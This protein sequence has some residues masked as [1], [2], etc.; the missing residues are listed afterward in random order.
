MKKIFFLIA[1]CS[2][3]L[4]AQEINMKNI[5]T[6]KF[7]FLNI[8][9]CTPGREK[10]LAAQAVDYVKHT[11][12]D[13]VLYSLTLHPEGF[14]AMDKPRKL[15]ESYRALKA[16]LAGTNVKLGILLQAIIGHWPRV[17]KNIE[18]WT[19]TVDINGRT[20]RFCPLDENFQKYIFDV[21]AMFAAEKP[22]FILGDDDIRSFSPRAECFCKLHTAL[23]NRRFGM[24]FSPE[25]YRLAVK[26]AGPSDP[27]Y[28]NFEQ[29]RQEQHLGVTTLI[30][31]AIDSVAPGIPAGTCM[32]GWEV[33]TYTETTKAIAAAGQ[34]PV[35]RLANADYFEKTSRRFPEI[36]AW[37]MALKEAFA[38][39]PYLLDEADTYPH[40][41]F[42]RSSKSMH[43]KLCSSIFSG[44][45]GAK[46]WFVNSE[47][48]GYPIHRNYTRILAENRNFYQTLAAEVENSRYN[49]VVTPCRKDYSDWQS[50]DPERMKNYLYEPTFASKIC[51][52]LG[53][54]FIVSH[55]LKKD[56][57]Y[58]IAGKDAVGGLSD[59]DLKTLLAGKLLLDGPAAAA[60]CARGFS[61][62]LGITAEFTDF[63]YNLEVN[64]LTGQ[65]YLISKHAD[66]PKFT[67][68]DK[69]AKVLTRLFYRPYATSDE[70]EEAAPA[71]VITQNH[72]GGTV[73]CTAFHQNIES[74]QNNEPRKLWYINIL[75]RLN[76]A[77]LP[78][79]CMDL[80]DITVLTR[81]YS[82]GSLLVLACNINF[83]DMEEITFRCAA[84]PAKVL[85]LLP[86]GSWQESPFTLKNNLISIPVD[87]SCYDLAV[88]RLETGK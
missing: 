58:S 43:A 69:N 7:T 12:N 63:R 81:K 71:T 28:K 5:F 46:V 44:L 67:V 24:N 66:V 34:P 36:T 38:D 21:V 82:N 70:L 2:L 47:K 11:G 84:P 60:V 83:D 9:P 16:E 52:L 48:K 77:S 3:V 42:S 31:K 64:T 8:L 72:L 73:C 86:D 74:A 33:R 29:L 19:R 75:D 87:M 68:I 51:G 35:L 59:E 55:D 27:V 13:V 18:S 62:E 49:G 22:V 25:E 39:I 23:F 30:R 56:M 78:L 15:L 32:P 85:K 50:T 17:D 53:I 45:R 26:N 76:G 10:Q 79:V 1:S 14:P 80:Q 57:V 54:P 61:R 40:S 37:T 4:S 41:L 88:F 6:K 20:V 65:H